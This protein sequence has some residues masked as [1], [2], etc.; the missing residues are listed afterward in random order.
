[1]PE[2]DESNG[3]TTIPIKAITFSSA[4]KRHLGHYVYAL[5]DPKTKQIFYVGKAHANER[6]LAHLKISTNS[7]SPKHEQIR[8]IIAAGFAAEIDILR[9]GL[10]SAAV[11]FEVEAAVIDAIGLEN[12]TNKVR[13]H[14]IEGGR[15]AAREVERLHGSKAMPIE[16]IKDEM[17]AFFIQ[18]TYSP[19]LDQM[20]LY[21]C[22]RRFWS[23]ISS[24]TKARSAETGKLLYGTALAPIAW[25]SVFTELPTGCPR[26]APR[27]HASFVR[28]SIAIYGN[29]SADY[30]QTILS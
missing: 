15:Q 5:V 24:K 8:S 16:D 30:F 14:R 7:D 17:I 18:R 23:K 25:L 20:Q 2:K 19:T 11:A 21:D 12:L 22:T 4:T 26:G 29:L 6:P 1:M 3:T 9:Y 10:E 13:G 28:T 27:Q